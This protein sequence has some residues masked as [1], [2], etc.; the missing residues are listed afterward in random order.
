MIIVPCSMKTVAA[1]RCGYA[2]NLIAHAADVTLK[3]R[4]RTRFKVKLEKLKDIPVMPAI[5]HPDR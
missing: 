4:R 5:A 1:I 3:E 2:D